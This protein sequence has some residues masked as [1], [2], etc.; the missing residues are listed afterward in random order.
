MLSCHYRRARKG[1]I[2]EMQIFGRGWSE[3]VAS[4]LALCQRRFRAF[5]ALPQRGRTRVTSLARDHEGDATRMRAYIAGRLWTR[6]YI[7]RRDGRLSP[8]DV[9]LCNLTPQ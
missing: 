6:N 8:G 9:T 2:A 3:G 7:T 4:P 1:G 5:S